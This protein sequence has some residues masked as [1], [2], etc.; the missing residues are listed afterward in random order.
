VERRLNASSVKRARGFS[1]FELMIVVIIFGIVAGVLLDRL[2]YYQEEAEKAAMEYNVRAIRSALRLRM[3]TM[4]ANGQ[5]QQYA[6]LAQAN[7][8]EWLDAVPANYLGALQ[9]PNPDRLA[10]GS[11]YF[12][13]DNRTLVYLVRTGR[14]FVPDAAGY[15]RARFRVALVRSSTRPGVPSVDDGLTSVRI[16]PVEPYRW[17]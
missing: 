13:M 8:M 11:W 15:K 5:A 2:N 12:D 1:L 14:R 6:T 7:P 10:P 17:Q 4:L 3:A 9:H 16:E